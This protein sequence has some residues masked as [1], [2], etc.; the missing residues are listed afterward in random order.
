MELKSKTFPAEHASR[1]PSTPS[2]SPQLH[3]V[4]MPKR[5][6]DAFY[7]CEEVKKMLWFVIYAFSKC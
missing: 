1:P 7:D 2:P 3:S 5:V 6:T 4:R